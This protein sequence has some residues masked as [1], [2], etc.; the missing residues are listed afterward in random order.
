SAAVANGRVYI[1]TSEGTYCLG[2]VRQGEKEKAGEQPA[3]GK[4]KPARLQIVHAD[5][6]LHPGESATLKARTFDDHGNL[7][8]EVK[9]EWSLPTPPLPPGAKTGPPALKGQIAD[10]KLTVDAKVPS[11]QGYVGASAAGLTAK[12]RV[13]VA[14]VLPYSQDFTK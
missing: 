1:S 7:I 9:V 13:R 10:G 6:V 8:G 14:P 2:K 4:G 3:A 5:L 12:A 11:Q